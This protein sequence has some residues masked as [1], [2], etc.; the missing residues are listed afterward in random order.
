MQVILKA[1]KLQSL[2]KRIRVSGFSRVVCLV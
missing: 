2:Q 1:G